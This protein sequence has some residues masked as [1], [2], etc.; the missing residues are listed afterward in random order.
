MADLIRLGRTTSAESAWTAAY[1]CQELEGALCGS[2]IRQV[3]YCVR[4]HDNYERQVGEIVPLGDNLSPDNDV[5]LAS[6]DGRQG[7]L[8]LAPR[9]DGIT[10]HSQDIRIG[11]EPCRLLLN[12]LSSETD[13]P[14]LPRPTCVAPGRHRSCGSTRMA[15]YRASGSVVCE[16]N[17][18]MIA[19][20]NVSALAANQER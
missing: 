1:L 14:D 7:P 18:A 11:K 5:N 12:L 6:R 2:E 15:D 20:K 9:R 19:S 10:I 16:R 13:E 17:I 8:I 3:Q 4:K